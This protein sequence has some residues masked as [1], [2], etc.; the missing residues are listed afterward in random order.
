VSKQTP[1]THSGRLCV[2]DGRT[3]YTGQEWR[4]VKI[5]KNIVRSMSLL[6]TV[7]ILT[8]AMMGL[9]KNQLVNDGAL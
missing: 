4:R 3:G 2:S 8:F 7:K 1:S 6:G 5:A 9:F